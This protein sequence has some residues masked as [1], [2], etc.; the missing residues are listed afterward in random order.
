MSRKG[1]TFPISKSLIMKL[2]TSE[3]EQGWGGCGEAAAFYLGKR[4]FRGENRWTNGCL[5][6]QS[7]VLS[8]AFSV[9][10]LLLV[11]CPA[12]PLLSLCLS[13]FNSGK[14]WQCGWG[15]EITGAL[16]EKW[17]W[18]EAPFTCTRQDLSSMMN[19]SENWKH[20]QILIGGSSGPSLLATFPNVSLHFNAWFITDEAPAAVRFKTAMPW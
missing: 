8:D 17:K 19:Q 6:S 7:G 3:L 10:H 15:G 12:A 11:E 4:W 5:H 14:V 1:S 16:G 20:R 18:S 13:L 2:Y 9:P